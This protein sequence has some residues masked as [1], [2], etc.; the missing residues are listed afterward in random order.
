MTGKKTRITAGSKKTPREDTFVIICALCGRTIKAPVKA[1]K[2][3][4]PIYSI[5]PNC[6]RSRPGN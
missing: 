4:P 2:T 3:E 6:K 5:C 1:A